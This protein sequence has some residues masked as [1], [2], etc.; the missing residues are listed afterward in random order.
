[1]S[2]NNDVRAAVQ[3]LVARYQQ[4][5]LGLEDFESQLEVLLHQFT[6]SDRDQDRALREIVNE[7]EIIRFTRLPESQS[8]AV[9]ES[10]KRLERIVSELP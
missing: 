6:V 10:L 1:M 9:D 2:D 5:S 3:D 8:Q 4:R 7:L